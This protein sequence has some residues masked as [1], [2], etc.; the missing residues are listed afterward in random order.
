[1]KSFIT[2]DWAPHIEAAVRSI[3]AI[4]AF[5]YTAGYVTG[6][7]IHRL[8][9]RL[10]ALLVRR[11]VAAT[12]PYMASVTLLAQWEGTEPQSPVIHRLAPAAS[13]A[14]IA[15]PRDPMARAVAKVR[16]GMS[17]RQAAALCGVSRSSLQR[18][19]RN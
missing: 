14:A 16:S 12:D 13:P 11:P 2:T 3:A 5:V 1:M 6:A 15:P 8:N 18:A 17:Q 9:D 4:A 10:A 7:W 19:L